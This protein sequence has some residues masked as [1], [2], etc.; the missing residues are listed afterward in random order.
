D[1]I[2]VEQTGYQT[3]TLEEW[4]I[5]SGLDPNSRKNWFTLGPG[6]PPRSIVFYNPTLDPLTID[7][8]LTIYEDLDR[9]TIFGSVVLAPY[10][11]VVLVDTGQELPAVPA[12]HP[13]I[14]LAMITIY[15]V[16]GTAYRRIVS[17]RSGALR[18]GNRNSG[19]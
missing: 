8:G 17:H 13:L 16:H 6:D 4:R 1:N 18:S 14:L 12:A 11:S 15:L 10:T 19:S 9:N 2:M 7:L 5:Y 3:Y